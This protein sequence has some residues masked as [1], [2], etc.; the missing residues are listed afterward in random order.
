M[1][2]VFINDVENLANIVESIIKHSVG[3]IEH[4]QDTAH[5]HAVRSGFK[6]K[7]FRRLND[8]FA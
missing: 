2:C 7:R 5:V 3:D 8:F 1:S 4:L 6:R